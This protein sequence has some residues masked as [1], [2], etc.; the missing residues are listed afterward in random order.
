MTNKTNNDLQNIT[1]K[2]TDLA[3]RTSK[4]TVGEL[5]CSGIAGDSCSPVG[6][7]SLATNLP[8]MNEER[9]GL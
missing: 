9:T 7:V 3:A 2:T 5:G 8:I 4:N 6:H 1:Q